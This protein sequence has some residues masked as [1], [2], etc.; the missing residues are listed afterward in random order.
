MLGRKVPVVLFIVCL[1]VPVFK[2]L[3]ISVI[4]FNQKDIYQCVFFRQLHLN[5]VTHA[6]LAVS[7][8]IIVYTCSSISMFNRQ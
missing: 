3:V 4:L 1:R 7:T 5:K 8:C 2:F 6:L